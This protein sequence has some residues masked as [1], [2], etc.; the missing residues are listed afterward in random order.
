MFCDP[1]AK[2]TVKINF[3]A[4]QKKEAPSINIHHIGSFSVSYV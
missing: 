3:H 4:K 2:Q 1:Y